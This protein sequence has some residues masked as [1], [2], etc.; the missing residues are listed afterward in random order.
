MTPRPRVALV[1]G[2]GGFVGGAWLIGALQA[3]GLETGWDGRAASHLVGTSAGSM[4]AAMLGCGIPANVMPVVFSGGDFGRAD[5]ARPHRAGTSRPAGARLRLEPGIPRP[6]PGS[7]RLALRAL[8]HPRQYAA[9]AQVLG[10]LPKGIF[11]TEPLQDVVR[12]LRPAGWP[13]HPNLWVVACDLRTAERVALGRPGAPAADLAVAVAASCAI[14]TVYHPVRIG[15]GLYVDGGVASPSN[16][17]L[18]A[19]ED[20]DFAICLNPTSSP[21]RRAR[22]FSYTSAS[23][24]MV[25]A[26]ADKLRLLGHEV[27]VVHPSAADARVMGRNLM[28]V[29]NLDEIIATARESMVEALRQGDLAEL[30]DRLLRTAP[31]PVGVPAWRRALRALRRERPPV[32][33]TEPA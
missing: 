25:M 7:L 27:Y 23:R 3:L 2:G 18:L 26:E 11:S 14:P 28:S 10:W 30:R 22:R 1:L 19:G 29:K 20:Y 16:L 15:T 13:A 31:A 6:L 8:A 17:D 9:G 5:P 21:A 33:A 4:I 12:R 32:P 24:R